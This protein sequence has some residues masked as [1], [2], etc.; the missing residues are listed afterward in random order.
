MK[1]LPIIINQHSKIAP[2][3]AQL[4]MNRP[5]VTDAVQTA[6]YPCL[7]HGINNF[8]IPVLININQTAPY[9]PCQL[10]LV[11]AFNIA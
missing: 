7:K 10:I 2:A 4:L 8:I 6:K 9:Q 11:I 1:N 5:P 3:V